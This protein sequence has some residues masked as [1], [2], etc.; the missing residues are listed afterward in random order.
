MQIPHTP[1]QGVL[2]YL[3]NRYNQYYYSY[4]NVT[5]TSHSDSF[6]PKNAVDFDSSS[7]WFTNENDDN[8]PH[9]IFCLN[10]YKFRLTGYEITTTNLWCRPHH[11]KII[12]SQNN[13]LWIENTDTIN[14]QSLEKQLE[15]GKPHY[16]EFETN[17]IYQCVQIKHITDVL[18]N[19]GCKL[20]FDLVQI[21]LFGEI[22][23]IYDNFQHCTSFIKHLSSIL[24]LFSIFIK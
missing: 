8:D 2:K 13:N 12:V 18:P 19:S 11:W 15:G 4:V 1:N 22:F 24:F 20:G 10:N 17:G 21:E 6:F 9:L 3:W 23:S 5:A 16:Y 7:Y 14:E